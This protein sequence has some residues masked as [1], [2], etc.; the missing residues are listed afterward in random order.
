[1]AAGAG[2]LV[3]FQVYRH[4]THIVN[5]EAFLLEIFCQR[6]HNLKACLGPRKKSSGVSLVVVKEHGFGYKL[7]SHYS[8]I[9]GLGKN[10]Y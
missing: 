2:A 1:M 9:A 8:V 10:I 7:H 4:I 6:V 3:H 5:M